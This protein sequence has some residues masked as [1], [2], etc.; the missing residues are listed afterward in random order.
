MAAPGRPSSLHA[1]IPPTFAVDPGRHTALL[2]RIGTQGPRPIVIT[3]EAAPRAG[4]TIHAHPP[5]PVALAQ[6]IAALA[7]M[8]EEHAPAARAWWA[9]RRLSSRPESLR[10]CWPSRK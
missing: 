2:A 1:D 4:R 9:S 6:V 10:G 7:V 3:S 8:A 5:D